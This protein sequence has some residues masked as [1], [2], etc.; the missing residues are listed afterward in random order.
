MVPGGRGNIRVAE[1]MFF[2]ES[3]HDEEMVSTDARD[4]GE[5]VGI[6]GPVVV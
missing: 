3:I 5:R 4:V 1:E 2:G 6:L